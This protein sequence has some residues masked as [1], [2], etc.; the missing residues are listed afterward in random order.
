MYTV[1]GK[2]LDCSLCVSL[3]Q[4]C[5]LVVTCHRVKAWWAW[6]ANS[7]KYEHGLLTVSCHASPSQRIRRKSV[8]IFCSV[9]GFKT[10]SCSYMV[11][12]VHISL[13]YA[14]FVIFTRREVINVWSL[15]SGETFSLWCAGPKEIKPWLYFWTYEFTEFC[16]V[17][18]RG[19]LT[20]SVITVD[21][22][23]SR[24]KTWWRIFEPQESR[25]LHKKEHSSSLTILSQGLDGINRK[26][27][28]YFHGRKEHPA[29][30]KMGFME[31]AFRIREPNWISRVRRQSLV[32]AC[33]CSQAV[34]VVVCCC[35]VSRL[36]Y[37]VWARSARSSIITSCVSFSLCEYF[38]V[39]K[40]RDLKTYRTSWV[41]SF[42]RH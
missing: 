41:K 2:M 7:V 40:Y 37:V 35:S 10:K 8:Q 9:G 13:F 39:D 21:E 36:W 11:R 4:R 1:W 14:L 16:H 27:V 3:T 12:R 17:F 33:V 6:S 20:M 30:D 32:L 28:Q 38:H 25:T 34:L 26:T 23:V 15:Q 24:N 29:G 31:I 18:I 5:C 22:Y 19:C 42:D